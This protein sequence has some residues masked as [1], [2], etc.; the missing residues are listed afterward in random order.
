[1]N[2]LNESAKAE[3]L[4]QEEL[5]KKQQELFSNMQAKQEQKQQNLYQNFMKIVEKDQQ[6]EYIQ[7]NK[8][9][10]F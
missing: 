7:P 6:V 4:P 3:G 9:G 8:Q 1:M 5:E 10:A 2:D